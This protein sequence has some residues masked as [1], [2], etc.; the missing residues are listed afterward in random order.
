MA[1]DGLAG[2][3]VAVTDGVHLQR[4]VVLGAAIVVIALGSVAGLLMVQQYDARRLGP[5][6]AEDVRGAFPDGGWPVSDAG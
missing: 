3:D 5:E 6:A 1:G 4:A 2:D